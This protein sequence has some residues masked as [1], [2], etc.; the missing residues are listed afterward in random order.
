MA[1]KNNGFTFPE[2]DKAPNKDRQDA[3]P[4]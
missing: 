4:Q 2:S 3:P 1:F